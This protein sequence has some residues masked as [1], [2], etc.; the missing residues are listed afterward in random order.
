[1]IGPETRD[2][3]ARVLRST[4]SEEGVRILFAAESGSRAWGFAST[5]S[6]YDVRFIYAHDEDWYLS[7][8]LGRDVIER[9]LDGRLVDLAGWDVRKALQLLLRSNPA[10][11]EWLCSPIVYVD[12]GRFRDAARPLF[13]R[14]ASPATL[15]HHYAGIAR[16]TAA[17]H[18]G[19]RTTV[20][21]KRYFYIIRPL[22]S[23]QWIV[24]RGGIPPMN[25]RQLLAGLVLPSSVV[26]EIDDL[27]GRKETMPEFGDGPR[28]AEIDRWISERMHALDPER[29]GLPALK[30]DAARMSADTL[31]R[32]TVRGQG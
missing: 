11:Y 2:H 32:T 18:L 16:K 25:I 31:F 28:I 1:M 13:E 21:L 7:L 9:P 26:A 10:L 19:D 15:A 20:N 30:N 24:E 5:D 3:I 27:I 23:L 4:A 22:L 8:E 17:R 14:N 29:I 6:D 12:D